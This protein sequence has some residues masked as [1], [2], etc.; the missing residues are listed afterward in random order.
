MRLLIVKIS[1]IGDVI[2]TLPVLD[3]FKRSFPDISIDWVTGEAASS[4]LKGNP[5]IENLVVYP[6]KEMLSM[7]RSP[8]NWPSLC[9]VGMDFLRNLR[10]RRYDMALDFQGL[11]KSGVITWLARA[12]IRSG[13]AGTREG[14]SFFL[15]HRLP[16]Y[17]P[18]EHAVDR[19]LRLAASHGAMA[20]SPAV[21]PLVTGENDR[22]EADAVLEKAGVSQGRKFAVLVP[23]TVWP[24]KM[25]T[26]SGFAALA[27][28]MAHRL[29]LVPVITGA[30]SD[31]ML[32]ADIISGSAVMPVDITGRTSLL[33]LAEIF[34]RASVVV[35]VDTGPM[36]LAVAAGARVVALFG[37]TAPWRTGPYG[38]GHRIVRSG[39]DC[40]PCFRRLC[41]SCECM[42]GISPEMVMEAVEELCPSGND[43]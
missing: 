28:M 1:A 23:G 26:V 5:H 36:H 9:R 34:R 13:F 29:G 38:A 7:A 6:Q 37:P 25:W 2:M 3:A 31:A 32:A 15:N 14:S 39:V 35:S 30:A 19:Y 4:V 8:L 41:D 12:D 43:A 40:S 33:S 16:P 17:D 21:F 20:P 22:L 11:L 42:S 18:D 24:T 27:D 10:G